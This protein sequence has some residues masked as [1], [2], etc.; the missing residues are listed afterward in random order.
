MYKSTVTFQRAYVTV[1]LRITSCASSGKVVYSRSQSSC[2]TVFCTY[3][4]LGKAWTRPGPEPNGLLPQYGHYPLHAPSA[5]QTSWPE[6]SPTVHQ[7][8]SVQLWPVVPT[9]ALTHSGIANAA[10]PPGRAERHFI[11]PFCNVINFFLSMLSHI[12]KLNKQRGHRGH[13]THFL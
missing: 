11:P 8:W 10:R 2:Y 6:R 13:T 9:A 7:Q 3:K 12:G 1:Y 4:L 5:P